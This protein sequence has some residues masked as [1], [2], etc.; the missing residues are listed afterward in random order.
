MSS[1]LLRRDVFEKL[2]I[3]VK[4]TGKG[5]GPR[6][7]TQAWKHFGFVA[8]L[9]LN[10]RRL[11]VCDLPPQPHLTANECTPLLCVACMFSEMVTDHLISG[12][13][14]FNGIADYAIKSGETC[15]PW[16]HL[17]SVL[18]Q[19][20]PFFVSVSIFTRSPAAPAPP[21]I[22]SSPR[23]TPDVTGAGLAC[24]CA[25]TRHE[26]TLSALPTDP[27]TLAYLASYLFH[28]PFIYFFTPSRHRVAAPI[29]SR[30]YQRRAIIMVG[31]DAP[32]CCLIQF[33]FTLFRSVKVNHLHQLR[34][35]N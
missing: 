29:T 14:V 15:S 17:P 4:S 22:F 10:S 30:R 21:R 18:L 8:K 27:A 32:K 7:S 20:Q 3:G 13:E 34:K 12:L 23:F 11:R 28:S 6:S 33:R 31:S 1:H 24:T 35:E 26:R 25:D 9:A 5:T 2:R 16:L 19:S